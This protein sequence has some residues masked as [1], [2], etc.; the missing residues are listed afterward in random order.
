[1]P[2]NAASFF[3]FV[4]M[5]PSSSSAPARPP[6]RR[7]RPCAS[8][9]IARPI[10]VIGDE[11]LLPY[12]RPPLSKKYLA[13]TMERDRLL[14]RHA[15]HY[16]RARRRPAPGLCRPCAS[17]APRIG[18]RSPTV[19]TWTTTRCCW[20]PA[21]G[22]GCCR[23]RVPSS[24][25]CTTC[26]PWRMST[27][28]ARRFTPGRRGVV[29]GGGYIGLEVAGTCREAGLDVT[30]LEAAGPG[31]EPGGGAGGIDVSTR[32][33]TR[34]MACRSCA[35]RASAEL[36]GERPDSP[37]AG[38]RRVVAVRLADG[39]EIP[40]DFVL[41]AIGVEARRRAGPRCRPD[42]RRRHRGRRVLPHLG[43]GHLGRRRLRAP[44]A[45]CTSTCRCASSPSTTPSSRAP[46]PRSTCSD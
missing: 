7:S 30:V 3:S 14:I 23:C 15:A 20:P 26:A 22:R 42:L 33:N 45:T 5:N 34:D 11:S 29:I 12:Q 2:R 8:A 40:A 10:T 4:C 1:M 21:A 38:Q 6:R 43:S 16:E 9:V 13:G 17:I 25:A 35:A 18:S 36:R 37:A 28:C 24:P 39:R 46:A 32:P 44:S 27:G 41:V 19:R 31:H